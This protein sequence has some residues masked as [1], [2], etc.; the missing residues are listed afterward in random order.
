MNPDAG[1]GV[2]RLEVFRDFRGHRAR[3][4]PR[5]ELDDVDFEALGPRGRS[6]FQADESGADHDDA[7]TR[8]DV[9]A[10]GLA[11]VERP[12]VAHAVEVGVGNVE[13]AIARAG[14]QHQVAVIERSAGGEQHLA[15]GAVDRHRAIDDQVDLL[16]VVEFFRPEHQAVGS[17]GPFQVGLG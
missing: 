15:R 12:Q 14:R 2:P 13:Q 3:H 10:Q 9:V 8:S 4:H 17:A 7:L 6:E 1:R 5:R 11:L 16:V